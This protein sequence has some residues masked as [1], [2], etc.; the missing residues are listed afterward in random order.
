LT[1]FDAAVTSG[2]IPKGVADT[3]THTK[4]TPEYRCKLE[5]PAPAAKVKVAPGDIA[6]WYVER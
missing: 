3:I 2:V 1:A 5:K 6:A 4:D